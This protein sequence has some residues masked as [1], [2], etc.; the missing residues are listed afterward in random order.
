MSDIVNLPNNSEG[1]YRKAL[2]A[3][4]EE[5]FEL[6]IS[7]LEKS[8][9]LKSNHLVF[10]EL[11]QLYQTLLEIEKLER[12]WLDN[13]PSFLDKAENETVAIHYGM[14]VKYILPPGKGLI[15]LYRLKDYFIQNERE[16]DLLNEFLLEQEQLNELSELTSKIETQEDAEHFIETILSI[17]NTSF[18]NRLKQLYLL[19]ETTTI[20][21]LKAGLKRNDLPHSIKSD[22]LHYFIS[23]NITTTV[24]LNWFDQDYTIETNQ[25]R[26]YHEDK[27]YAA[28]IS[29]I[30][31][32]CQS[33]NPHLLPEIINFFNNCVMSFY[34][35]IDKAI[36]DPHKWLYLML[37]SFGIE[38]DNS[39]LDFDEDIKML[40]FLKTAQ[41]ELT[42]LWGP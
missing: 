21:I 35:F 28:V 41:K 5:N 33:E 16:I 18:I 22:M 38:T 1:Y 23:R 9:E 32:Y 12:I 27:T 13:Y 6:G 7:F 20:F 42:L 36:T 24:D 3:I 2:N 26:P 31:D 25:L 39:F 30:D 29:E 37:N 19:E 10:C 17:G 11:V 15:E 8:Y 4:Q 34:P 40:R 14:T